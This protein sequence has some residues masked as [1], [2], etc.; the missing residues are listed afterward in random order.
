MAFCSIRMSD[1]EKF[2]LEQY[3]VAVNKTISEV[4]RESFFDRLEEEYD[5]KSA[6]EAYALFLKNP[7]T[8]S[9]D[10]VMRDYGL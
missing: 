6:D 8:K 5:I 4:L 9:L 10:D 7:E 2:I 3:A 1:E